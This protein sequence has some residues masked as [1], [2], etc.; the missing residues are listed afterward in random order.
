MFKTAIKRTEMKKNKTT[1][2]LNQRWLKL[3]G[4]NHRSLL[5]DINIGIF[6]FVNEK[7]ES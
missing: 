4:E 5:K 2:W 7:N 1:G 3:L 6:T